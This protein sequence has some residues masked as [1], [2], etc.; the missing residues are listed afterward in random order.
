MLG[1]IEQNKYVTERDTETEAIKMDEGKRR[2][3]LEQANFQLFSEEL[4][5]PGNNESGL[6]DFPAHQ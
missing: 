4:L 2:Q 3:R 5:K 1:R 6:G